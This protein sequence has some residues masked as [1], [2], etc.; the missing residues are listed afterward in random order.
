MQIQGKVVWLTGASMGIGEA[1]AK[2]LDAAGAKLI[3][4]ARS[5]DKLQ[6]L[7]NSLK[8]PQQHRIVP[9]DLADGE[10]ISTVVANTPL[11]EG[12]DILINNGGISQRGLATDTPVP[13]QRQVMEVNYFGTITLT[14]ALLPALLASKGM[15]V[16]IASVAGKVGG[17]S[18]SGYAASKHALI[19]YMDCLRAEE[20]SKGLKVLNVCPGFVQTNI[21]VHAL[22]AEGKQ[23]G[24]VAKSIAEGISP[25]ACASEILRAMQKNKFEV[26]IG[27]GLSAWA[28][29]I[30]R[31]FPVFFTRLSARKNIR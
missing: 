8:Y 2:T 19:G 17:Q 14:Q 26:V 25:Q 13:V 30:K 27:K 22:T 6:A 21:S 11:P 23:Y 5:E 3:L 24:R 1:L 9:L 31:W 18:M 29:T 12:L 15:I 10:N 4:S 7:L 20:A 28:P 16:N